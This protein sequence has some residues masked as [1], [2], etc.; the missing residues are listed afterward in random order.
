M[1]FQL[2]Q[3]LARFDVVKCDSLIIRAGYDHAVRIAIKSVSHYDTIDV[4]IMRAHR[5]RH[6]ELIDISMTQQQQQQKQNFN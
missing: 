3:K 5:L 1:F 2:A 4:F 6:I